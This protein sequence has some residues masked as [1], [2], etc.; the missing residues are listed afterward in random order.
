[1]DIL[2][3][4]LSKDREPGFLAPED[5]LSSPIRTNSFGEYENKIEWEVIGRWIARHFLKPFGLWVHTRNLKAPPA[6]VNGFPRITDF[7]MSDPDHLVSI[8]KR[9]D[10]LDIRNLLRLEA[11][12]A[13]LETLQQRL[14]EDQRGLRLNFVGFALNAIS[15]SY[16][17]AA[18]SSKA[19]TT[20]TSSS[21]AG[22]I[23]EDQVDAAVQTSAAESIPLPL[24]EAGSTPESLIRTILKSEV[25]FIL[26]RTVMYSQGGKLNPFPNMLFEHGK[27]TWRKKKVIVEA[28][29]TR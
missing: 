11:R 18:V 24:S 27:R 1:M 19:G 26:E 3:N 9:F 2:S 29:S 28:A 6:L 8:F 21:F 5:E 7:I 23:S 15:M 10:A 22:S 25:K 20:S 13:A 16:E 4:T 14:D 12:V 17:Y